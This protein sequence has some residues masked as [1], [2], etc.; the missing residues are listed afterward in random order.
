MK[1]KYVAYTLIVLVCCATVSYATLCFS[2]SEVAKTIAENLKHNIGDFLWGTIGILLTFVST[3]L[4]FFTFNTQQKQFKYTQKDAFRTR[5]EGTFFNMLSMYYKVRSEADKQIAQ[6]S[7]YSSKSLSDFYV[8]FKEY[9]KL[10]LLKSPD[11]AG[12]MNQLAKDNILETQYKTAIFDLGELY[13]Q[14]IKHQGCN[15]GFYFRYVHNLVSFVLNHWQEDNKDIHMYLNFIQAQMSDEELAL[16]FYD[17][18]S[19]KGQDKNHKYT[20][21]QNLDDH[22]FLENIS[23]STLVNRN[24]YKIFPKTVFRF[25]ND[26]EKKHV[27]QYRRL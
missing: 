10:A 7:K 5:F 22:S 13:D 12:A 25:L 14:Y 3:L 15:A 19:N 16:V 26:D 11:F 21:K 17:S 27:M 24:H 20:F 4:L 23:E 18:I 9:Y 6:Y 2:N 1:S 8:E